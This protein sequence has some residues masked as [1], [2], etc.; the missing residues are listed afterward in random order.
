MTT[1]SIWLIKMV[2]YSFKF[3]DLLIFGRVLI[4]WIPPLRSSKLAYFLYEVT[5][6]FLNFL[7]KFLP[8]ALRYPLDFSPFVALFVLNILENIIIRGL[9]ALFV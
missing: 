5:E 7:G 4:S 1:L 9:I 2:A 6:P 8:S 3:F